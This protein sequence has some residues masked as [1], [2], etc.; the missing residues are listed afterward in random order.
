MYPIITDENQTYNIVEIHD[1]LPH[2]V[3]DEL[4]NKVKKHRQMAESYLADPDKD[5]KNENI[6]N[7]KQTHLPSSDPVM[8]DVSLRI[9]DLTNIPSDHQELGTIIYY[10]VG[11]QYLPHYDSPKN[12]E[13]Q[14]RMFGD[15]IGRLFTVIIYLNDVEEGGETTFPN[16]NQFVV[17]EKGK[18]VIF[19]NILPD[20]TVLEQSFHGGAPVKKGEKWILTKWIR[21]K[22]IL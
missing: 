3:C 10:D 16:V 9:T 5:I 22:P 2:Q 6:R 11:G 15:T 7:S 13:T 8:I 19:Q 12:V 14:K 21:V 20:G 17:P 1:F 4:I 18:A